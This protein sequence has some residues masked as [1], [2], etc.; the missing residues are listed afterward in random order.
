MLSD[1]KI[2]WVYFVLMLTLRCKYTVEQTE[3][4]VALDPLRL[5]NYVQLKQDGTCAIYFMLTIAITTQD[6][7]E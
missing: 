3:M 7:L 5:N 2:A 6:E 1:T 4:S